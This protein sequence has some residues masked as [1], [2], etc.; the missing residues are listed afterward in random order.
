MTIPRIYNLEIYLVGFAVVGGMISSRLLP[1]AVIAAIFY[2]SFRW[3]LI[4]KISVRTPADGGVALLLITIPVT[5]LVTAL[6]DQ[7]LPQVYRLLGGLALFYAIVNW[8]NSI[9]RLRLLTVG[10][11]V[12]AALL[13]GFAPFSV[14]WFT[15]KLPFIPEGLYDLFPTLVSDSIHPNVIAGSLV[16]LFPIPMAVL[17]FSETGIK[18]WGRGSYLVV[19]VVV[20]LILILTKSRGAWMAAAAVMG[21]M[22]AL[23]W[24]RGWIITALVGLIG[25][26]LLLLT[27]IGNAIEV[28][29]AHETLG[30]KD[31][32]LEIWS[33]A[34]LMILDFP[35][36]GVGMGLFGRVADSIFPFFL[37]ARGSVPHTHNL[38]LQLA[39]DLGLP[40]L[41]AWLAIFMT[42]VFISW[43]VY[44]YGRYKHNFWVAGL[45]AGLLCSQL[46]LAVHGLTD[47]VTWGMVRPAPLV[48]ALWGTIMA[49][50]NLI[51]SNEL[52]Q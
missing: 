49:A 35:L 46:A 50:G 45:G 19:L 48:W 44:S 15:A 3:L 7:T 32:R 22:V 39:V 47:A 9:E 33:R 43:K 40:G 37:V 6:P 5:L 38:Y 26:G 4:R 42:A 12:A 21:L 30:G 14:D 8:A 36:T 28:L 18:P 41:I 27:G 2:M 17:A 16:I 24:R 1:L 10:L 52:N 11:A 34:Y 25:V 51:S 29:A 31:V 23:R 13:A 20:V